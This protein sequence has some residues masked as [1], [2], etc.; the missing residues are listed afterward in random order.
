VAGDTPVA[1]APLAGQTRV[2]WSPLRRRWLGH[3]RLSALSAARLR[4]RARLSMTAQ[5]PLE[6]GDGPIDKEYQRDAA[7]AVAFEL[8]GFLA[9]LAIVAATVGLAA[10]AP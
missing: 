10:F 8:A 1:S 6:D 5:S 7:R 4:A 3:G 9:I 2:G